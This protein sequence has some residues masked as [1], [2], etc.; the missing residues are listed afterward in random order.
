MDEILRHLPP[1]AHVLDLGC[2]DGSFPRTSYP[3]LRVVALDRA[4]GA[5]GV[6]ADAAALP[7]QDASFDA[8]IANHSLEHMD[9]LEGVLR[10]LGR[11]VRPGGSLYVSVPDASTFSDRLYRWIYH[12]G[13]HVN[14]FRDPDSLARRIT[15]ATGLELKATRP[16]HASF[17]YLER[18]HFR[19][20]PPRRM[21]LF[22]NGDRRAIIAFSYLLRLIDRVFATRLSVYGW[23]FWFGTLREPV[24]TLAWTNVCVHCGNGT[25]AELLTVRRHF[26][27]RSYI[28]RRCGAWN[29]FTP[30]RT[31][32]T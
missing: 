19:P 4:P 20:R 23:G 6:Q 3:E 22:A 17:L 9:D 7:F 25:P 32:E 18:H 1:G 30:D 26:L 15:R 5:A 12:G 8:L 2:R 31:E 29:L 16:L 14:P 10:E 28:C 21:W 24:D 11:V 27:L 13:G